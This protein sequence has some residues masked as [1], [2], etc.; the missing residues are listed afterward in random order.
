MKKIKHPGE[1]TLF[2][3]G[4]FKKDC[5]NIEDV[6][7]SKIMTDTRLSHSIKIYDKIPAL[8]T[9][10]DTWPKTTNLECWRCR[11]THKNTPWFEPQSI[12][13]INEVSVGKILSID[14]LKQ[15]EKI[16]HKPKISVIPVGS[17]CSCNC[18]RA[19]IDIYTKNIY[20]K[21]NKI[22]MLHIIYEIFTGKTIPDIQP[23]ISP[24]ELI[25]CGGT[26]TSLE[27]QQKIESLDQAYI[28]ELHDNNFMNICY[29]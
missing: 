2:L 15:Q 3:Q 4:V 7:K 5:N 21:K 22:G 11:R 13:P 24:F 17:F 20:E 1:G 29:K 19:F 6:F 18:V 9:G 27:Y 10:M 16:Q 23:S 26:L 28:R 8:F 25:Q 12:E 14:E